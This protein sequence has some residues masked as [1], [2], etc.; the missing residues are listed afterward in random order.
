MCPVDILRFYQRFFDCHAPEETNIICF[1]LQTWAYLIDSFIGPGSGGGGRHGRHPAARAP[2]V[3][4]LL[5]ANLSGS[6]LGM[7]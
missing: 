3:R 2:R 5:I 4:A 6:L 1:G 7:E